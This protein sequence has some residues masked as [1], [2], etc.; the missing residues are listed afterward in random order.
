M[1]HLFGFMILLALLTPPV[2]LGQSPLPDEPGIASFSPLPFH[3]IAKLVNARY[4]GRILAA[5]IQPPMKVERAAGADL[6][7]EFRLMTPQ[8]NLLNI[9]LDARD[10]RFMRVSGRG[11]I[12]A[13]RN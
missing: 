10:G 7:Y 1:R 4:S 5:R 6:I 12:Q 13:R 11:Q 3:E 9:R 2:G 8:H